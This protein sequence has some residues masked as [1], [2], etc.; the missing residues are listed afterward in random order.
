MRPGRRAV[1]QLEKDCLILKR[2]SAPRP[3]GEWSDD[4]Y[5]VL[6]HGLVVGR[7]FKVNAAPVGEPWM[8]T[9]QFEHHKGHTPTHGY[10]AT[11]GAA[12]AALAKAGA[13]HSI[14]TKT[15]AR[16]TA[17]CPKQ[18][19]MGPQTVRTRALTSHNAR[20]ASYSSQRQC[21]APCGR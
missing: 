1:R 9:L 14:A 3:S 6:A 5:D 18:I 16:N 19:G 11:R 10:A 2:A 13:E 20:R 15:A 8:W 4:D 7:I 12:M 21:I 17:L